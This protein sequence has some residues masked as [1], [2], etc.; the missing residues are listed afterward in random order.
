MRSAARRCTVPIWSRV[1]NE[2]EGELIANSNEFVWL[3]LV[4]LA[5]ALTVALVVWLV[6]RSG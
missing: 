3:A 6:R 2:T 1:V 5:I 4:V